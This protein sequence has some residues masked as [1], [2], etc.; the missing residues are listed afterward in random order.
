[1]NI[2]AGHTLHLAEC[3]C[4]PW[5]MSHSVVPAFT[6]LWLESY[7]KAAREH[8]R[9]GQRARQ[10]REEDGP[11]DHLYFAVHVRDTVDSGWLH[12]VAVEKNSTTLPWEMRY[13][14]RSLS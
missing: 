6:T 7:G 3:D 9:L 10:A 2:R 5:D 4:R 8:V 1:M 12:V 13:E 11:R 14:V